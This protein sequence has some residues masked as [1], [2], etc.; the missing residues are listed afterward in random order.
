[1]TKAFI[2][3]FLFASVSLAATEVLN[4]Q[5]PKTVS[6][7]NHPVVYASAPVI[8]EQSDTEVL[9]KVFYI[10][11]WGVHRFEF[12]SVTYSCQASVCEQV[13][14]TTRLA[15]FDNCTGLSKTG[16]PTCTGLQNSAADLSS[17]ESSFNQGWLEC[18]LNPWTCQR[19]DEIGG[20]DDPPAESEKPLF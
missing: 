9:A 1:M 16:Q 14:D 4:I 10:A 18:E 13:S 2:G 12:G 5:A 7:F 6:A 20:L 11:K 17:A 3:L 15:F 19:Y 8:T